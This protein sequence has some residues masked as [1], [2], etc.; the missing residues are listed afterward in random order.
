[1]GTSTLLTLRSINI[2]RS[3]KIAWQLKILS[4]CEKFHRYVLNSSN[5]SNV[6]LKKFQTNNSWIKRA[7]YV[8]VSWTAFLRWKF[9]E[10]ILQGSLTS[11]QSPTS[12]ENLMDLLNQPKRNSQ[13]AKTTKFKAL[14]LTIHVKRTRTRYFKIRQIRVK[15]QLFMLCVNSSGSWG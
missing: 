13:L 3:T 8:Q 11:S 9:T 12:Q 14:K 4:T 1:M 15:S 5:L 2:C 7:Q 6:G 10:K